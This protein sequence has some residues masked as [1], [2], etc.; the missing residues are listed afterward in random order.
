MTEATDPVTQVLE[1]YK[2]AVF[3]K[4][5]DAF[6]ALYTADVRVFDMWGEWQYDGHAAWRA[7][8]AGWFGSLGD[9]RVLVDFTDLRTTIVAGLAVGHVLVAY[10]AIDEQGGVLRS[11]TSRLSVVLRRDGQAWKIFHEHSSAPLDFSTAKA[12]LQRRAS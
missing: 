9:E 2:A 3:A 5:V 8:A 12:I 10:A 11:L 1:A 4:D 7:M 6:V